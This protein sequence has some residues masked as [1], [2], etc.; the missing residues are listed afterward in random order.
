VF[1]RFRQADGS[2]T[3]S[4]GGLGLGLSIVRHLVEL[5]GG[6]VQALSEGEGK[7]ATFIVTLPMSVALRREVV[8][9]RSIAPGL[10][11]AYAC[12]PELAHLRVLIVDDEE[13][14]REL[15]RTLL[16][17]CQVTIFTAASAE[18]GLATLVS[19]R[20]DLLVSDIGMPGVDGYG[21]ISQVRALSAEQG[22]RT[23]AV[24]LTAY[25]R[26]EDRARILL[27]GFHSHVSK[28]VEP[29]E[30]LAV[31]ASLSGRFTLGRE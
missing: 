21:L 14:T 10:S 23:P 18:E 7:G 5:H 31:L 8:L 9:P 3:R 25:A 17:G 2:T 13:D 30:L 26:M 27:A 28:P 12:P 16:E 24:A 11:R 20:P 15:L 1:D 4:A 22:G 6:T 19:K 29:V